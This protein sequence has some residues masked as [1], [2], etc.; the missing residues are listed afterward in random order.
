MIFTNLSLPTL[1]H[2]HVLTQTHLHTTASTHNH[3]R[4]QPHSRTT[5]LARTTTLSPWVPINTQ[6]RDVGA[7]ACPNV[8]PYHICRM[9]VADRKRSHILAVRC[10][11]ML[12]R[13]RSSLSCLAMRGCKLFEWSRQRCT[14]S[15]PIKWTLSSKLVPPFCEFRFDLLIFSCA[16]GAPPCGTTADFGVIITVAVGEQKAAVCV[17]P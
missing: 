13:I 9:L 12:A 17:R 2:N 4:T 7:A 1:A 14:R 15:T 8:A 3:A 11:G 10:A 5:T 16:Q 6:P